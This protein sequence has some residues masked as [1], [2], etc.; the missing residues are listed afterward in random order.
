MK[1]ALI[2]IMPSAL[3]ALAFFAAYAISIHSHGGF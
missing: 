3:I 1:Y 2:I